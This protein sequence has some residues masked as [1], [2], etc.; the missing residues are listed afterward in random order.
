VLLL[1]ITRVMYDLPVTAKMQDGIAFCFKG[2]HKLCTLS[3]HHGHTVDCLEKS[4]IDR[5]KGMDSNAKL[6]CSFQ[7]MRDQVDDKLIHNFLE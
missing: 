2:C 6:C 3:G 4:N 1:Q 7:L 5:K